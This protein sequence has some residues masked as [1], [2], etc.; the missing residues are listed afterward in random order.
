MRRRLAIAA[1]VATAAACGRAE[2]TPGPLVV[3]TTPPAT[4][5]PAPDRSVPAQVEAAYRRAWATYAEAV[6]RLDPGVLDRAF[7]GPALTLRRAEVAALRAAGEAIR[8]RVGHDLE[9]ALVDPETAVVTDVLDNHMVRVD[10]ETGRALEP[11]PASRLTR[12][13]TLRLQDG[14]WKVTEAVAL[15]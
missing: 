13:T 6:G 8:V 3:P 10:A 4:L 9:V 2:A 1:L 15:G 12:A 11:D 14:S 5:A 7:A